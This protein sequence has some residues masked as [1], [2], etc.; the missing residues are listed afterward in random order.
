MVTKKN[1][2]SVQYT[3]CVTALTANYP[4]TQTWTF[5]GKPYTR[6][7]IVNLVNTALTAMQTTKTNHDTWTA[8]VKAEQA[9]HDAVHPVLLALKQ[10]LE[11][12]L[13]PDNPKIAQYGFAA[14]KATVRTAQSK[15]ASA[16]KAAA[17]RAKKKAALAAAAA[18][19]AAPVEPP[20]PAPVPPKTA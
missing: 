7:D 13:G 14:A 5:A 18:Q 3:D 20:P 2:T 10:Q 17:T 19:P 16:A 15:A 1:D 8:S 12:E 9:A 6:G 11:V 4:P